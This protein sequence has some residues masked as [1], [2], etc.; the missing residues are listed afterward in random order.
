MLGVRQ[1]RLLNG[2]WRAVLV[3]ERALLDGVQ[4]RFRKAI[5]REQAAGAG[6][7]TIV[8]LG[9]DAADVVVPDRMPT[10][11]A[12]DAVDAVAGRWWQIHDDQSICRRDSPKRDFSSR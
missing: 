11:F 1:E 6:G 10:A 2:A 5:E 9:T 4:G 8:A 7:V 3:L 12:A